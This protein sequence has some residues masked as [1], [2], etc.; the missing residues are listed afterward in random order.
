MNGPHVLLVDDSEDFGELLGLAAEA[1]DSPL[2]LHHIRSAE[3]ALSFLRAAAKRQALPSLIVV[4]VKMPGMD[5]PAF[6]REL[7]AD[8]HLQPLTCVAQSDSVLDKDVQAMG[9][10]GCV[11]YLRKPLSWSGMVERV[12][13]L[14]ELA[15]CAHCVTGR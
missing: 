1:A 12:H 13:E 9:A 2:R 4:D 10:L 8:R 7:R 15:G 11:D 6:L 3:Q 5:G 14:A